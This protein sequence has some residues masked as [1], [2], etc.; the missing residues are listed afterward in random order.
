MVWTAH[1][2]TEFHLMIF[3]AGILMYDRLLRKFD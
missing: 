1:A 3:Q 2:L